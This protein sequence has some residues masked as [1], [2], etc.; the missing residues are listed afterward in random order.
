MEASGY[1]YA[2]DFVMPGAIL[3]RKMDGNILLSNVHVFKRNHPHVHEMIQLRDY[4]RETPCEVEAYS[5]LKQDY[6]RV[7]RMSTQSIESIKMNTWRI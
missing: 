1:E 2:G 7:T 3:F 4:L 5:D 6:M